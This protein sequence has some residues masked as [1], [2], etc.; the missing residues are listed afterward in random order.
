MVS[1]LS[2]VFYYMWISAHKFWWH[3][4][5]IY[6]SHIKVTNFEV[7][8]TI[9]WI[10]KSGSF[11][12]CSCFECSYRLLLYKSQL[13]ELLYLN[14]VTCISWN[15]K[16]MKNRIHLFPDLCPFWFLEKNLV[17]QKLRTNVST[18]TEFPHLRVH[19]LKSV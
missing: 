3:R 10:P 7:C 6:Y 13:W 12:V 16:G 8:S 9:P 17:T 5:N 11:G 14:F 1:L 15:C 19:K 4:W 2:P 18:N